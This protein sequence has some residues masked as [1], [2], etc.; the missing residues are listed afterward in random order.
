[1]STNETDYENNTEELVDSLPTYYPKDEEGTNYKFLEVIGNRVDEIDE[2]TEDL[3]N[4]T[5][6]QRAD[7][8]DQLREHGKFVNLK[9]REGESVEEYRAR[10]LATYQLLTS[11]GT[12]LDLVISTAEIID[13]DTD[14]VQYI[15]DGEEIIVR[16]PGPR[17]NEIELESEDVA[18]LVSDLAPAG[19]G[20]TSEVRGTL[21][22]ITPEEYENET[23]ESGVGYDT[24]VNGEPTGEGGTYTSYY[25]S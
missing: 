22:Y 13:A 2:Y 3:D 10:I 9:K 8:S 19:R 7:T 16:M 23:Y 11:E 21:A 12:P 14:E 18:D 25:E 4:A 1:M 24:L 15:R 5:V 17:V 20:V 6:V